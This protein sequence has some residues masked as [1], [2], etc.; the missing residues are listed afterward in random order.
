MSNKFKFIFKNV[1][2]FGKLVQ[3]KRGYESIFIQVEKACFCQILS[4]LVF[5]NLTTARPWNFRKVSLFS[6]NFPWT[7]RN[8]A[9]LCGK[10]QR[11]GNEFISVRKSCGNEGKARKWGKIKRKSFTI[12]FLLL[13]IDNLI[14]NKTWKNGHQHKFKYNLWN[15]WG[16]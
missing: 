6:L 1:G 3:E 14:G 16:A 12:T 7:L 2:V 13:Y 11:H 15:I 8:C 10:K 5:Q 9:E 4:D